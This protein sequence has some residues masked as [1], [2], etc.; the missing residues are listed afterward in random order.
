MGS[1]SLAC[2]VNWTV[3]SPGRPKPVPRPAQ[4]PLTVFTPGWG[5]T[6]DAREDVRNSMTV[7]ELP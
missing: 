1:R 2:G 7:G 6:W 3:V 4:L 5:H